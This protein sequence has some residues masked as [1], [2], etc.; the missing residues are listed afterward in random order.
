MHILFIYLAC[1]IL[2]AATVY[3]FLP[4]IQYAL[5]KEL[6][7]ER[8]NALCRLAVGQLDSMLEKAKLLLKLGASLPD[9]VQAVEAARG[10]NAIPGRFDELARL[11][12]AMDSHQAPV[13]NFL[14]FNAQGDIIGGSGTDRGNRSMAPYF[15]VP[16]QG[17]FYIGSPGLSA[18]R[19]H[20]ARSAVNIGA[21][22]TIIDV[23][24]ASV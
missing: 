10:T 12:E 22:E 24:E 21:V 23:F 17:N 19:K 1:A 7:Q 15:A 14:V 20:S 13:L 9:V 18:R 6:V 11:V 2:C 8:Q 4:R 16:M 3:F 5:F